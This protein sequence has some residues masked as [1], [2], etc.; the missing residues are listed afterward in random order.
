[1]TPDGVIRA[2]AGT[3]P[4]HADDTGDSGPAMSAT[5]SG[6]D[7]L[8]I[9]ATGGLLIVDAGT[10]VIRDIQGSGASV[11]VMPPPMVTV[12][13]TDYLNLNAGGTLAGADPGLAG[14]TVFVDV[15]GTGVDDPGDPQAVTDSKGLFTIAG[16]PVGTHALRLALNGGDVATSVTGASRTLSLVAGQP[17]TGRDFGLRLTATVAPMP[18]TATPFGP[19]PNPDVN[20]AVVEG[21]YNLVLGRAA[22]PG[23]LAVDVGLL[24]G[25]KVTTMQLAAFLHTTP[26]YYARVLRAEYQTF[27]GRAADAPGLAGWVKAMQ[28]GRTQAQIG[29]GIPRHRLPGQVGHR[30]RAV[31]LPGSDRAPGDIGG[32]RRLALLGAEPAGR[33][34]RHPHVGRGAVAGDR[35]RLRR[36]PGPSGERG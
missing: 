12:S 9:D 7:G 22:D 34:D 32:P 25:G 6:P 27:L 8:A 35:R 20:A 36:D 14:R 1:V 10:N 5:L 17:A 13:G 2:V 31:A 33:G 29:R 23:G 26:E 18:V 19:G 15:K 28:P 24:K 11:L 21:L 16:V 4:G 3:G 30:V